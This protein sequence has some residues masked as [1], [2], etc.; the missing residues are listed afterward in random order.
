MLEGGLGVIGE[1]GAGCIGRKTAVNG[2]GG[3]CA[4][5]KDAD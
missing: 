1:K 3:V 5:T 2:G 4:R